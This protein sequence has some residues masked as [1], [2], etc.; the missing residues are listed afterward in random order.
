MTSLKDS[1]HTDTVTDC[2]WA[3]PFGRSFHLIA[4]CSLDRTLKIW[5]LHLDY[6]YNNE[7]YENIH[8][9]YELIYTFEHDKSV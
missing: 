9:I 8:I 1:G 2:Q 4:S 7:Q 3:P 5:K 6:N